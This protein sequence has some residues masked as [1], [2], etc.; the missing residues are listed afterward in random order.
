M[1]PTDSQANESGSFWDVNLTITAS[2]RKQSGGYI[3]V[4]VTSPSQRPVDAHVMVIPDSPRLINPSLHLYV[5]MVPFEKDL[6]DDSTTPFPTFGGA[7]HFWT[8]TG[9]FF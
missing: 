3:P 2:T 8:A 4:Q 6:A 9:R 1:G 7:P 5:I